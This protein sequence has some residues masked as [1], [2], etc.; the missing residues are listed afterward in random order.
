MCLCALMSS[1]CGCSVSVHMKACMCKCEQWECGGLLVC[2]SV[3]VS[4]NFVCVRV[5]MSTHA[6]GL[7]IPWLETKSWLGLPREDM[8]GRSMPQASLAFCS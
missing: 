8:M 4:W 1:V 3:C 2:T 5:C 6:S 7:G